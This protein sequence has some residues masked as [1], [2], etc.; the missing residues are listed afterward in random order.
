[1]PAEHPWSATILTL[2]E[3]FLSALLPALRDVGSRVA[4]P[5]ETTRSPRVRS[6]VCFLD[7][8]ADTLA[9]DGRKAVGCSQVRRRGGVLIHAAILLGVEPLLYERVFGGVDPDTLASSVVSR[10]A[11]ALKMRPGDP[12]EPDPEPGLTERYRSVGRWAPVPEGGMR[13][14][15]PELQ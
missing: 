11:A 14:R 5:A 12:V 2:Y 13:P 8:L 7:Q 10:L 9:V 3:R 6:P 4:R 15:A 1:M